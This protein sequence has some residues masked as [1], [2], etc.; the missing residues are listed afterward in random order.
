[1]CLVGHRI[2]VCPSR[3]PAHYRGLV[4]GGGVVDVDEDEDV[5][6]VVIVGVATA[7]LDVAKHRLGAKLR[8]PRARQGRCRMP[9]L[10]APFSQEQRIGASTA[11][12]SFGHGGFPPLRRRPL[13][14]TRYILADMLVTENH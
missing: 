13:F 10:R 11:S 12:P 4:V 9:A 1:M 7:V 14:A 3:V 2:G 5:D 8:A 6:V